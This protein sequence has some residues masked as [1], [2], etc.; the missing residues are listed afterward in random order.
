MKY[1]LLIAFLAG[2]IALG[3]F[4]SWWFVV[5]PVVLLLAWIAIGIVFLLYERRKAKKDVSAVREYFKGVDASHPMAII[6]K[7]PRTIELEGQNEKRVYT[8]RPLRG[9][10][11]ARLCVRFAKT[12]DKLKDN[13][14]DFEDTGALLGQV[15]EACE[16]DFFMSLAYVVYYSDKYEDDTEAQEI[17]NVKDTF[18][19]LMECPMDSISDLLN[20]ILMQNDISKTFKSFQLLSDKI[21]KKV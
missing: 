20:I 4:V 18:K 11:V 21:K 1:L 12:L 13:N 10:H 19:F 16:E 9:K 3:Y 7:T 2:F 17:K 6:D 5:V 15:I 8:I 14:L